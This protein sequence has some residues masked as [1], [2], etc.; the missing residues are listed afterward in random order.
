MLVRA[1]A[2]L[3]LGLAGGGTDVS[4]FCDQYGGHV[5]NATINMYAYAVL[6]PL[7]TN[8]VIFEASDIQKRYEANIQAE[9]EVT[10]DLLLH[11][12]VYNRII[13]DF[14]DGKPFALRISTYCQAPPGSGLGSSSTMVVA[15]LKAYVEYFNLPLG[16]YEIAHLAFQIERQDARL[17]GGRQDQY[18]ATFGG[19]NFIEFYADDRV[20][21]NPLRIK[22]WILS[23]LESS[24]V[25]FYTNVSRDSEVIIKQQAQ[26]VSDKKDQVLVAMHDIKKAAVS[27][28]E[29]LLRGN[30]DAFAEGLHSGWLA[31]KRT[32]TKVTNSN[33][34]AIYET[35]INSGAKAGK[36]SGAGGGG[37]FMFIVNPE[38]KMDV[39]RAL[40]KYPGYAIECSF[41]KSGTQ[42]WRIE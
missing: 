28:K 6:E 42:G 16:E 35:A 34:D 37:F 30:I 26:N 4:P 3:R 27:M 41:T 20:I 13:R 23:E 22:N 9:Y 39:L 33:L 29:N 8:K 7:G 24:L 36:I 32:A 1:R 5:L 40:Q 2:P 10:G 38:K 12:A 19:F 18:A 11:K 31:K 15:M 21:V 25:L 17:D 14:L